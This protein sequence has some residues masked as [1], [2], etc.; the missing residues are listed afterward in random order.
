MAKIQINYYVEQIDRALKDHDPEYALTI[1]IKGTANK[2][3]HL[4]CPPELLLKIK[5]WYSLNGG[6]I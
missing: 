6:K 3:N 1:Q 5:D 4:N 2:S